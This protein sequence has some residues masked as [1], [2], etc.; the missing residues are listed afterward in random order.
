VITA[1]TGEIST[2]A[3]V[4][5]ESV[6]KGAADSF[7]SVIVPGGE[8]G[9]TRTVMA[10]APSLRRNDAAIF[11][12]TR[13]P[14]GLWRPVGLATGVFRVHRDPSRNAAVV[15]AP[16]TTR[17]VR[18]DRRVAPGGTRARAIDVAEFESLVR[19]AVGARTARP[20]ANR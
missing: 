2:V 12:L 7:V 8:W 14:D 10:G 15:Q 6:L 20:R 18:A 1:A 11:C 16:V 13:G 9:G 4:S 5:V 19:L 3:T 17:D